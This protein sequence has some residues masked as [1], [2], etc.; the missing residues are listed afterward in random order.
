MFS[1]IFLPFNHSLFY[2]LLLVY[3]ILAKMTSKAETYD[4]KQAMMD[5]LRDEAIQGR[6]SVKNG[7][8][9]DNRHFSLVCISPD[10]HFNVRGGT[11]HGFMV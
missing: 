2:I 5:A 4:S 10:C 7:P 3:H 1:Y 8:K 9:N 6:R 11:W